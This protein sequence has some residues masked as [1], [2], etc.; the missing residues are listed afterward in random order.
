MKVKVLVA[1]SSPS[2]CDPMDCSL[3]VSSVH[4]ILQARILE[5]FPHFLLQGIFPIQGSNPRLLH[6]G[7]ILY[8]LSHQG[9]QYSA[10]CQLSLSKAKGKKVEDVNRSSL[11]N[12]N[13][14][15]PRD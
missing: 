12:G 9:S 11:H 1:Q 7:Q 5:W 13:D 4:G 8:R 3:P 14:L 2:L 10:G 6:C 15:N